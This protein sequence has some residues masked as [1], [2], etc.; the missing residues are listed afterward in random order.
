M[1]V[2]TWRTGAAGGGYWSSESHGK[3]DCG[4]WPKVF[5]RDP[6]KSGLRNQLQMSAAGRG[7]TEVVLGIEPQSFEELAAAMVKADTAAALRAFGQA[8]L[9]AAADT[10]TTEDNA[11]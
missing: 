1:T 9:A 3:I 8:L 11:V 2:R 7:Y 4:E 5:R 6:L 10:D